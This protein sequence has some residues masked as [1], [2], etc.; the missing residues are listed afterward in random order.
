MIIWIDPDNEMP[1]SEITVLMRLDDEEYPIWPGFWD[2]E[3]WRQAD[4]GEVGCR[5]VGWMHLEN[6]AMILDG[7]KHE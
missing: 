5:V 1:D 3:K 6:A 4:A 2:G 7:Q